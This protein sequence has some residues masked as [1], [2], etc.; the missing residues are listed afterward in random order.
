MNKYQS[1]YL[2]AVFRVVA[3]PFCLLSLSITGVTNFLEAAP[4]NVDK[5]DVLSRVQKLSIPFIAN[6]GQMDAK[7]KYY[8]NTF[9]GT[10]FVMQDGEIIYNLPKAETEKKPEEKGGEAW[11]GWV[12]KEEFIGGRVKEVVPEEKTNTKVS[13]II[14]GDSSKW[15]RNISTYGYVNMGEV[16]EGIEVSLKAYGKNM[17]KL[18]Y[19]KAEA[20]PER[21]HMK[22]TG[23]MSAEVNEAGE[24]GVKTGLGG[25]MFSK[26]VAYQ[27]MNGRKVDVDV[28]YTI[29]DSKPIA[30]NAKAN[31][32][33]V[34]GFK[35]GDYDKTRPLVIDPL[36]KSTYLGGNGQEDIVE[37][38]AIDSTGNVYVAG[39]TQSNDFPGTSTGAQPSYGGGTR[40]AF[41]CKLNGSLTSIL[42][43]T[44]LGGSGDDYATS[45]VPYGE[46]FFVA[47]YTKSNNFP[48][49][50]GG[51]QPSYGG[52]W[53]GFIV[54]INSDLNTILQATYLGGSNDDLIHS[55]AANY[56]SVYVTGVTASTNLPVTA[57]GAQPLKSTG[58]MVQ[59]AFVSRL[60]LDLSSIRQSTYLGGSGYDIAEAIAIYCS[61]IRACTLF[62]QFSV[63][64]G[65]YTSSSNFPG[66][67]GGA[68]SSHG[69]GSP[70]FEDA[71]IS[72]FNSS[73]TSLDQ[74]TYLGG[75]GR[76]RANSIKI[77]NSEVYVAGNTESTNFPGVS[78]GFQTSRNGPS[79]VFLSKLNIGLTSISQST[80]LGG[81]YVD[82]TDSIAIGSGGDVY[83]AGY[84]YSP[85]FP[86]TSGG[87]QSSYGGGVFDIF[88]SR[89]NS[90]LNT[91]IQST[92]LGGN[93]DDRALSIAIYGGNIYV[94][95]QTNSTNFPM[96]SGSAQPN[97]ATLID[98]FVSRFDLSL[99]ATQCDFDADRNTDILWRHNT[100]A[101]A[102]WF[103]N[104]INLV[105]V[106]LLPQVS[107]VNWQ[108]VGVA[109]F[110][111]DGK[112]DILW[113]HN[114]IGANAV[115]FMNGTNL[116]SV[117]LLLPVSDVNWQIVG[118]ADFNAD[119]KPDI[120]WRHNTVGANAVWIMDG[121]NF[122][123]VNLLPDISDKNWKIVGP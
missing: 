94:T 6:E 15:K 12:L 32:E 3:L 96:T 2:K 112:P 28:N 23:G 47:G 121:A 63:F 39:H 26:P 52:A 107:D 87:A 86:G 92:Y 37:S 74:S 36:L 102:L 54:A 90:S 27:E 20:D 62:G 13:Y 98:S 5:A 56:G 67:T 7:V 21:I 38:V 17:E 115:W 91:L 80:Y 19:V 60:P 101:N 40:D 111:A 11:K 48:G 43:A 8:V 122:G 9:G 70:D 57:G 77:Y 24:L 33:F 42:S 29:L 69:G 61:D 108:I 22:L 120:L 76:D 83:V 55:I 88:V 95:G 119:G 106:T 117:T 34:Y 53:D 116:V 58:S 85:N 31:H 73:L 51:A 68:Q 104:G 65:G 16:Y 118:V 103:M 100:G 99:T 123:N 45:I 18:F 72:K 82:Y 105:S 66:T 75:N 50:A 14:G 71:F 81:S 10:V 49:T 4:L 109:D 114:T 110:N 79:D 25:V 46:G 1:Y 59:D 44:Y 84:T 78:G 93:G 64:V 97:R 41:V 35:I 89:L 113:R 30:L